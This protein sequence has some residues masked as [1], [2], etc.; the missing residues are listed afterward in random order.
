MVFGLWPK[1]A[2]KA[3]QNEGLLDLQINGIHQ[4]NMCHIKTAENYAHRGRNE[5]R[6][7]HS[8][9]RC[10]SEQCTSLQ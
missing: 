4:S 10:G 8:V 7:Q 1:Q 6:G 5:P 3:T 2:K 9:G